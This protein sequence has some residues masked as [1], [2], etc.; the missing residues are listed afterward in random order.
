MAELFLALSA[1]DRREALAVASAVTQRPVHLLEKD[2][3]VVWTLQTLFAAPFADCLVFK[4]G[5]SLS[6]AYGVIRRFSEDVDLTYDIR[7]LAPDLIGDAA[8]SLPSNRSQERKWT[9]EIRARLPARLTE[10]VAPWIEQQ[11]SDQNLRARLS[12]D[13]D[14]MLLEYEA[15]TAQGDYIRPAVLLEF[16]AR[17]TGEP[18]EARNVICDAA[19]G[20]PDLVFPLATPRVMRAE[21]TFWEKATAMHVYCA[22]GQFRGGERFARHW[23]DLAR[24]H[25]VGIAASASADHALAQSVARHKSMFFAEKDGAG[26]WID[27]HAAV[28]GRL[29]LTPE[30][31]ARL[32]LARDYERMVD[33]GLLFDEAEPFDALMASCAIIEDEANAVGP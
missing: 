29:R 5:T 24:L 11:L 31:E 32:A 1:E 23:H 22:Q 18:S 16:G 33:E 9:R 14:K 28:S 13:A 2:V 6:K 25:E 17:S 26:S 30:G 7:A 4:G 10:Q 21:R 27:Y 8:E 19:N 15:V 20:L 3:W 12:L